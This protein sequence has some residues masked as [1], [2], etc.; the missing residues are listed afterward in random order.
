APQREVARAEVVEPGLE[1]VDPAHGDIGLGLVERA[2]RRGG[3]K[4]DLTAPG[5]RLLLGHPC[6]VVEERGEVGQGHARGGP[7][8]SGREGGVTSNAGL[9]TGDVAGGVCWAPTRRTSAGSR[10]SIGICSPDA[11]AGSIVENGAAT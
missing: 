11:S 10:S 5:V 4:E 8:G 3:A 2:R 7:L 6:R 1:P 9:N